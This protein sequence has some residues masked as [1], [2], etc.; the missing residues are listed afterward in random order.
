MKTPWVTVKRG[1]IKWAKI[2]AHSQGK[3]SNEA[4]GEWLDSYATVR[5]S[6]CEYDE[7]MKR[8]RRHI[9]L[10]PP[11]TRDEMNER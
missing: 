2:T 9:H 1:L 4:I 7:L 11:Y 3:T 6:F 8:L 5:G 10:H